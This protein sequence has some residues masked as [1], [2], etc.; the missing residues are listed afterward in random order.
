MKKKT[1]NRGGKRKG[2][3]RKPTGKVFFA[4]RVHPEHVVLIE[5]FILGLPAP[6]PGDGVK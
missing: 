1:E 4:K 3:G 6:S 2:S 5:S